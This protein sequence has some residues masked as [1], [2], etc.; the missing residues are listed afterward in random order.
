MHSELTN[1]TR[2]TFVVYTDFGIEPLSKRI[3]AGTPPIYSKK[4]LMPTSRHPDSVTKKL[5]K[6]LVFIADSVISLKLS[7]IDLSDCHRMDKCQA[8]CKSLTKH[9]SFLPNI[10]LYT[11]VT[12]CIA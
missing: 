11:D 9:K 1:F 6:R 5:Y 3:L 7:E 12:V 8:A 10:A 2:Y 4:R